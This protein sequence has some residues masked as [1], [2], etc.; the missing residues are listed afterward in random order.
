[1]LSTQELNGSEITAALIER[2]LPNLWIPKKDQFF[3]VPEL[4]LLGS[5][6]L[7]LQAAKELAK[8]CSQS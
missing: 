6:K 7:D 1:V 2:G 5:G 4:P 3:Q 8:T